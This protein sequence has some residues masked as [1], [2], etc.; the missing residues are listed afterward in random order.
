[1]W[2]ALLGLLI[3]VAGTLVGKVLIS[4]GIGYASYKGIDVF[5]GAAKQQFLES[6]SWLS[7]ETMNMVGMLQV[8]T[9]VNMLCSALL[10]RMALKG[11]TG[12]ALKSMVLK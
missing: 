4:L 8:G 10:A 3:Q 6:L 9:C 12:G 2:G 7:P 5:V 1:V 11:M